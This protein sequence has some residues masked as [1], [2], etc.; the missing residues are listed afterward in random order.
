MQSIKRVAVFCASSPGIDE[1][2][3]EAAEKLGDVLAGEGIAVNFGGGNVGLMGRLADVILEKKGEITGYIPQFMKEMHWSHPN[4]KDMILVQSMHERK[5]QM[6]RNAEGVIV[7]PGGV[8]TMDEL[9]EIITLK[10]LGQ[11]TGPII[12]VNTD[13]FYDPLFTLL[14]KMVV[15]KFMREVHQDIWAIVKEPEEVIQA[16]KESPVWDSGA[17]K[18][19]A[20]EKSLKPSSDY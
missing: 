16:M 5:Y 7:L 12:I 17:I 3:F 1:V 9:M 18:F 6:I 15:E 20:V 10:Q 19:A 11:F 13:G 8:G 4:V 14:N 2:Y